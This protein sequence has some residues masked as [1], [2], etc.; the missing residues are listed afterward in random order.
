VIDIAAMITWLRQQLDEDGA[1]ARA[2]SRAYPYADEGSAPPPD[3]AHWRWGAGENWEPVTID[4][5]ASEFVA[6]PGYSCS[7]VTVEEWP[8]TMRLDDGTSVHTRMM[9]LSYAENIVEMDAAAGGHIVRHD[10]ARVLREVEAKWR[11]IELYEYA[12]AAWELDRMK[13][14]P[15]TVHLG[16]KTMALAAILALALPYA[17][18]P[19][20]REE[21]R[22]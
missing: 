21:W 18:R 5:A 6:E 17:D 2:A 7:L 3:G 22:P 11:I 19:G 1:W 14:D 20:Y 8:T 13:L 10:P 15:P 12:V 4:P 9:P 16:E